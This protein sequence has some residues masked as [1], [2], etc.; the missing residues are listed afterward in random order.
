MPD[1]LVRLVYASRSTADIHQ[2][3]SHLSHI[4]MTAHRQNLRHQIVGVLFYGNGYFLQCIEGQRQKVEALYAALQKD[5]RHQD[6]TLMD[7]HPIEQ[8]QFSTWQMK[9]VRLDDQ[10]Q[11]FLAQ[12]HLLPFNPFEMSPPLTQTL[13]DHLY[14]QTDQSESAKI[15]NHTQHTGAQIAISEQVLEPHISKFSL[16]L[17]AGITLICGI[18]LFCYYYASA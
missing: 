7:Q 11:D 5:P 16:M 14:E 6:V 2:L 13:I 8:C 1:T 9:Y 4:L 17:F 10:L 3:K 15:I 18:L 12:H